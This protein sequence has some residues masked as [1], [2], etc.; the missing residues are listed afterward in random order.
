M[1]AVILAGGK[2]ARLAPYTTILPKPL[3]P[4]GEMPILELM[5]RQL[6]NAGV[7][8]ITLAV[9][10]LSALLMAYFQDGN[11]LGVAIDYA[12]ER[13]PLGTAAPL[14]NVVDLDDAFLVMNGDLLTDLDFGAMVAHHRA[15]GAMATVGM[16]ERDFTIEFGVVTTDQDGRITSWR[17]KPSDRQLLSMG[18]YVLDPGALAW[19]PGRGTFDLPDLVRALVAAGQPVMGHLHTGYWLDI[20][21]PNDYEKA[22]EDIDG[23]RDHFLAP[24]ATRDPAS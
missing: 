16:Y 18:A 21:R 1:R 4:V 10:H 3:L 19:I 2:G 14:R 23:L 12:F 22:Q 9:G 15:T 17:E 6:R 11:D 24:P 5:I 7:D 13:E 20:G 8:R